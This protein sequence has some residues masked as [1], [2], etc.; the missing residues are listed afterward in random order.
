MKAGGS[1]LG[2]CLGFWFVGPWFLRGNNTFLF[3]FL[4]AVYCSK[5][6]H[7]KVFIKRSDDVFISFGVLSLFCGEGFFSSFKFIWLFFHAHG[8]GVTKVLAGLKTKSE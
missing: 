1:R 6:G 8:C 4:E 2:E 3:V 7:H 5:L